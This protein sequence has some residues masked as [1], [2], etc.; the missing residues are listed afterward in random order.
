MSAYRWD[1]DPAAAAIRAHL[2]GIMPG[3]AAP[4]R[5]ITCRCIY[6]GGWQIHAPHD[7]APSRVQGL[8]RSVARVLAILAAQPD[9]LAEEHAAE[10][11]AAVQAAAP[12]LA[13]L[14]EAR[15]VARGWA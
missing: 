5:G 14:L 1:Q 7:P 10:V 12:Q 2:A 8:D 4:Y 9:P 6:S 13:A 15:R 3:H 11:V